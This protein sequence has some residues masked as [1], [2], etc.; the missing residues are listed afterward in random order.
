MAKVAILFF[1]EYRNTPLRRRQLV[2]SSKI[3]LKPVLRWL[4][5][6]RSSL[7]KPEPVEKLTDGASSKSRETEPKLSRRDNLMN[8]SLDIL[9]SAYD[10]PLFNI[11]ILC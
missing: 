7:E 6:L 8:S 9:H 2:H 4:E 3:R 1:S 5:R 11:R 10:D